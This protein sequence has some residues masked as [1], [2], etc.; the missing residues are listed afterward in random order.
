M[1]V[2]LYREGNVFILAMKN[3]ENRVSKELVD[4]INAH[5]DTIERFL[6]LIFTRNTQRP[7]HSYQSISTEGAV[8]LVT[9]GSGDFFSNGLDV[10]VLCEN[11]FI[12]ILNSYGRQQRN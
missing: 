10:Q 7:I 12:C 4:Q 2:E 3:G 6:H 8:A 1:P 5:L 9:T 11:I